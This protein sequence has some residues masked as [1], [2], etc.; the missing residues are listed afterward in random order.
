VAKGGSKRNDLIDALKFFAI[1]L[2]PLQHLLNLRS[3][4]N[5]LPGAH[6]LVV[7]IVSFDMPLFVF[8]S[9]Y[10]LFGREGTGAPFKFLWRKALALLV[11]YFAWVTVEMA[12]E[13]LAMAQWPAKLGAAAIQPHQAYQMWFLWVLFMLFVVFTFTRLISRADLA[14]VVV[15]IAAEAARLLPRTTVA[16]IDKILLL[17]PFL[18]IGYLCAKHRERLRPYERWVAVLSWPVFAVLT[19]VP[20]PTPVLVQLPLAVSGIAAFWALFRLMPPRLIEPQAWV[21]RKSLGIYAGQ[22]VLLPYLIIGSGYVGVV[23]SFV[24][25]MAASTA[26]ATV[27]ELTPVTR[28]LFL[29][30]WPKPARQPISGPGSGA[31]APIGAPAPAIPGLTGGAATTEDGPDH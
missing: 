7:F 23:L 29:G 25:T 2:V 17:T 28:A 11:P 21:G 10:V 24:A 20:Q 30:Q 4:F 31:P 16:G 19:L 3:E 27:L 22:M 26:L 14:L 15:A 13:R 9:G 1:S 18:F 6:A 5:T 8:L 12:R